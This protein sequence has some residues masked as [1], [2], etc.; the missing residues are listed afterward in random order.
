MNKKI[1]GFALAAYIAAGGV[2]LLSPEAEAACVA[3]GG[4]YPALATLDASKATD[5]VVPGTGATRSLSRDLKV[6]PTKKIVEVQGYSAGYTEKNFVR[7]M[8]G[9]ST[10]DVT[11]VVNS[12]DVQTAF[13]SGAYAVVIKFNNGA[14]ECASLPFIGD[15]LKLVSREKGSGFSVITNKADHT[16][17]RENDA[18]KMVGCGF[19]I[20]LDH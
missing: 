19:A 3:Q 13:D 10:G 9:E 6:A 1:K 17:V 18:R 2:V 4:D 20:K 14:K 11:F 8:N 16:L 7:C 15:E 12:K 5:A